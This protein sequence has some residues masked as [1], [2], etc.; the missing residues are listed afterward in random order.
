MSKTIEQ[1]GDRASCYPWRESC[2]GERVAA[3]SEPETGVDELCSAQ[4]ATGSSPRVSRALGE[5]TVESLRTASATIRALPPSPVRLTVSPLAIPLITQQAAR[6]NLPLT[7]ACIA[8]STDQTLPE[9]IARLD[10]SDGSERL[11]DLRTGKT[12]GAPVAVVLGAL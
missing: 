6:S 7:P 9:H 1:S 11:L 8:L 5:L 3:Q 12:L 4:V 10:Y 2:A